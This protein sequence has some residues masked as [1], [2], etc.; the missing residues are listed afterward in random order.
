MLKCVR[1]SSQPVRKKGLIMVDIVARLRIADGHLHQEAA[2]E[3]ERLRALVEWR[4]ID[5]PPSAPCMVIYYYGRLMFDDCDGNSISPQIEPY[6]DEA[7]ALGFWDGE[8]FCDLGTGHGTFE[9]W[10]PPEQLP[11]RWAP[12]LPALSS[13]GGGK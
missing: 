6:R 2:H 3:I 9:H 10:K 13:S 1:A 8:Q 5:E 12:L 11:T 7:Y 4:P